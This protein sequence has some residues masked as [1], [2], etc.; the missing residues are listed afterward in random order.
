MSERAWTVEDHLKKLLPRQPENLSDRFSESIR[1]DLQDIDITDEV[2]TESYIFMANIIKIYGEQ[3]LPIFER[4][5]S[6]IAKRKEKRHILETAIEI[7]EQTAEYKP[8]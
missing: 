3:F 8:D 2:L 4:L 6:E 1:Q 5:H 7:S